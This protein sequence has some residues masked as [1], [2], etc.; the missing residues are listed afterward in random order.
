MMS[1]DY[2]TL[3]ICKKQSDILLKKSIICN[4][5]NKVIKIYDTTLWVTDDD[6]N[7]CHKFYG[8][9]EELRGFKSDMIAI[10]TN[11]DYL[12]YITNPREK[13]IL[14]AIKYDTNTLRFVSEINQTENICLQAVTHNGNVLKY[15]INQTD[16]I[17]LEA[18]KT[19]E[20]L[21]EYKWRKNCIYPTWDKKHCVHCIHPRTQ[22]NNIFPLV[23]NKT[24]IICLE[25]V[26]YYGPNL[27]FVPDEYKTDVICLEAVKNDGTVLEYVSNQ[28]EN[29]CLEAVKNDGI[30]L[31]YVKNQTDNICLEAVKQ[32]WCTLKY[33]KNQT[34]EICNQALK[35]DNGSI[36]YT[37]NQ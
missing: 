7:L 18:I 28:T 29:I 32:N 23:K 4:K 8:T 1:N 24:E 5:C 21:T 16:K 35:Q 3:F 2:K 25:A 31:K 33:V 13:I 11:P 37:R 9:I 30:A 15:V 6:D 22:K 10:K 34:D 12:Q 26:K 36:V 20:L 17:C 27:Q 14:K 19:Y